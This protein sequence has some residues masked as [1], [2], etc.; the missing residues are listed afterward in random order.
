[1]KS[2][3]LGVIV[4]GTREILP[5]NAQHVLEP[6]YINISKEQNKIFISELKSSVDCNFIKIFEL[7]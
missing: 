3:S 7:K 4:P 1:V 6:F 2:D 5:F